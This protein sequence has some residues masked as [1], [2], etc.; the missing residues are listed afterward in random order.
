MKNQEYKIIFLINKLFIYYWIPWAQARN[1]WLNFNLYFILI[2]PR[3]W[4]QSVINTKRYASAIT[5]VRNVVLCTWKMKM[6]LNV[7]INFTPFLIFLELL[8]FSSDL[9]HQT[10][11]TISSPYMYSDSFSANYY[12]VASV[13][14]LNGF[15][16]LTRERFHRSRKRWKYKLKYSK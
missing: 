16:I 6:N 15:L 11:R 4:N 9:C 12:D 13:L 1:K 14:L 8:T 10:Y 7:F 5:N 2:Q 3:D